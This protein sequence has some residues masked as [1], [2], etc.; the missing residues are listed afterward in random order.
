MVKSWNDESKQLPFK[1]IISIYP[2]TYS[3]WFTSINT[4]KS[5]PEID[6]GRNFVH[7][8]FLCVSRIVYFDKCYIKCISFIV[9][10]FQF[11]TS[12]FK[13]R[14]LIIFRVFTELYLVIRSCAYLAISV[15]FIYNLYFWLYF[16]LILIIRATAADA[17]NK[18]HEEKKWY[19]N[20]HY[21][22]GKPFPALFA[23]ERFLPERILRSTHYIREG[24]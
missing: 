10:A 21:Q 1:N 23:Q 18:K 19:Q 13:I 2:V 6:Q 20:S 4:W 9:N 16:Y 11:F 3:K 8:V 24:A 12:F 17:N 7:A 22:S 5:L 15:A 14:S